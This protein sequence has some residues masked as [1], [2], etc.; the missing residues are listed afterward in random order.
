M[1][2]PVIPMPTPSKKLAR[3][4]KCGEKLAKKKRNFLL[5]NFLG[6]RRP[7]L[8]PPPPRL[9]KPAGMMISLKVG[10]FGLA[11]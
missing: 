6:S 3:R 7:L 8:P 2:M 1:L 10:S 4:A 11:K 5:W 9:I